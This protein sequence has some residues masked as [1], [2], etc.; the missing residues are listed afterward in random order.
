MVATLI[1]RAEQAEADLSRLRAELEAAKADA[2]VMA[3]ELV[4]IRRAWKRDNESGGLTFLDPLDGEL[5]EYAAVAE[6]T[7][8]SGAIARHATPTT[9]KPNP[10]GEGEGA[11]Q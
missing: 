8:A 2:K 3:N 6:A 9:P 1:A 7:Q 4:V 10:G 5:D 11:T